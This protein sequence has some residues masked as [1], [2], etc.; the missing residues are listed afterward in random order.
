PKIAKLAVLTSS[1]DETMAS[2]E[3]SAAGVSNVPDV[4]ANVL[5]NKKPGGR[6]FIGFP[7]MQT[8]GAGLHLSAPSVIPTVERAAIDLI[9]RWVRSWNQEMLRAAG[10]VIRLTFTDDMKPLSERLLASVPLAG[11][12]SNK[13]IA[14]FMPDAKH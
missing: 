3:T 5:P 12:L 10:I 7:T 2:E 9:A 8:T 13:E 14:K 6:V 4:F 11:K 1:F